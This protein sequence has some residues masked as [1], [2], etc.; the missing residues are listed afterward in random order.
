[1]KFKAII[2]APILEELLYR[3]IIFGIYRD[4]NILEENKT[5]CLCVL[6]LYFAIAHLNTFYYNKI[7][8]L[9]QLK[10]VLI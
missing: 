10:S 4:S 6:P 3:S 2:A 5:A 1:M 7:T 9:E 8:N